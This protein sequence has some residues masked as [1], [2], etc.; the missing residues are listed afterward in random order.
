MS[1][2]KVKKTTGLNINW[3]VKTTAAPKLNDKQWILSSVLGLVLVVMAVLQL[4]GFG[5]FKDTLDTMGLPAATVWG[6]A[7]ILAELWGAVSFFK[8]RLSALFRRVGMSLAILVSGFWFVHNLQLISTGDTKVKSS[9]LFGKFMEQAP[10]WW[11]AIEVTVLLFAVIY[12]CETVQEK[13][14][15]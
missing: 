1:A 10:G 8:L 5:D 7:V 12:I 15:K 2:K 4:V 6:V 14:S 13:Y 11:S 9:A 3:N